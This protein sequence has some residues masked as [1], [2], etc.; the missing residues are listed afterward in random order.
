MENKIC[1]ILNYAPHY[2]QAIYRLMDN[3][4][5]CDFYFGSRLQTGIKKID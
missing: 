4:L 3:E 5:E 1:C 2:R